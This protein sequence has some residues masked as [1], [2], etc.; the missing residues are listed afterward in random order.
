MVD[1]DD[2]NILSHSPL[3]PPETLYFAAQDING[4]GDIMWLV[5]S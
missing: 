2:G 1:G 3:C 4:F 5:S